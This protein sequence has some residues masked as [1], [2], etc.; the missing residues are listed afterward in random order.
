MIRNISCFAQTTASRHILARSSRSVTYGTICSKVSRPQSI[1]WTVQPRLAHNTAKGSPIQA[2]LAQ[3]PNLKSKESP[4]LASSTYWLVGG[5]ILGLVLYAGSFLNQPQ[6]TD[7]G[8]STPATIQLSIENMAVTIQ[9]GHLGNLTPEQ[10]GKLREMWAL[11]F[12]IFGIASS[13]SG[14]STPSVAQKTSV[15]DPT[16]SL[17][18][19]SKQKKG[20][21]LFGRKSAGGSGDSTPSNSGSTS[22]S[23]VLPSTSDPS[24]DKHNLSAAYQAALA[25]M[26]PAEIRSAFW[27]MSKHDHPDALLLRFL[28]ARKW[29]V[30]AAIVM[31][32]SAL[33]WRI[34]DAKVDSDVMFKGES[35]MQALLKSTDAKEKKLGKDFMD[36]LLMGKSFLYGQDK[37]GRP[38][39]YV[40]VRLHR[41]GE[42][43]E[44]S[45]ERFT[46]WTIE[47]A[48][49]M[50]VY[51][52][53]TAVSFSHSNLDTLTNE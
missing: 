7:L 52:V 14:T 15:S 28:R 39:C 6:E 37:E 38:C 23:G 1:V 13:D 21:G 8:T 24:N 19:A 10:E 43:S 31:A 41:A 42:Q 51:P 48:R 35:G 47:T 26:T 44:E 16:L 29:D 46:V 4:L 49:L 17:E 22:A 25:G 2:R 53:T 27:D 18:S 45:L 50:L 40:R 12:Q 5:A 30:Q 3:K 33:H 32:I 34:K 11:M 9:P 36:Q 20:R